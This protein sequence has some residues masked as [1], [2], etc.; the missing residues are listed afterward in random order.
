MSDAFPDGATALVT[1]AGSGIGRATAQAFARNGVR[2]VVSDV[3][4]LNAEATVAGIVEAGGAA[5]ACVADASREEDIRRLVDTALEAYGRLDC[6]VNNAGINIEFKADYDV[7]EFDRTMAV[8]CRG[9][10]L[11]MKHEIAAMLKLGG[12]SIVNTS[13]ING[14]VGNPMQPGYVTSKHAVIGTTRQAALQFGPHGIRVNAV[15]PGIIATPMTSRP[16]IGG[17]EVMPQY[18]KAATALGRIGTPEEIAEAVLWLSSSK[19][20][21][22]TGHALVVDGGFTAA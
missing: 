11:A 3:S 22:V 19:A 10:F 16:E 5:I 1:G 13:S 7:D 14:L 4:P 21:Y 12:G 18:A 8:N 9:V 17:P 15:C 2:V 6:A 20:S